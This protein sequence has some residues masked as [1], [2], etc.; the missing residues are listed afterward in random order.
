MRLE[1][2]E[3]QDEDPVRSDEEI[4]LINLANALD[5]VVKSFGWQRLLA[6][7]GDLKTEKA[8]AGYADPDNSKD[9]YKGLIAGIDAVPAMVLRAM[10]A[11]DEVFA[12]EAEHEEGKRKVTDDAV[13]ASINS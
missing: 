6:K 13:R 4:E 2:R 9:Y 3:E 11:R 8:F 7:I 12:R 10:L 5:P 1:R